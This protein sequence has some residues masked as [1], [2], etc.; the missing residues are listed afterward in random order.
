MP[1]DDARLNVPLPS[2]SYASSAAAAA[3]SSSSSSNGSP[4]EREVSPRQGA[5]AL[6]PPTPPTAKLRRVRL[7]PFDKQDRDVIDQNALT[8]GRPVS[9]LALEASQV[10]QAR[11]SLDASRD[12]VV[13]PTY[14]PSRGTRRSSLSTASNELSPRRVAPGVVGVPVLRLPVSAKD[15]KKNSDKKP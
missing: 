9:A 3:A 10:A 4:R 12:A 15:E 6:P 14:L 13:E 1:S 2:S 5:G 7:Q 8:E 11:H